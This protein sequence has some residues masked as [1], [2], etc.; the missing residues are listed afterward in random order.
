M[1]KKKFFHYT[2]ILGVI[3][4]RIILNNEPYDLLSFI[5]GYPVTQKNYN[6]ARTKCLCYLQQAFSKLGNIQT[7]EAFRE[8]DKIQD[9][10]AL[11]DA[12]TINEWLSRND[13]TFL[14]YGEMI[15]IEKIKQNSGKRAANIL[16]L[17]NFVK[18]ELGW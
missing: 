10:N 11:C 8:L 15:E 1:S 7:I 13:H 17:K 3:H 18:N 12:M 9:G 2:I 16:Y 14:S 5:V 6:E 4:D